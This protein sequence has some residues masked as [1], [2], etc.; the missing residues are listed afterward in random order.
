MKPKILLRIAALLIL[1]FA[2]GHTVSHFARKMTNDPIEK[3]VIRQMEQHKFNVNGSMRSR[4]ELS[5]GLSFD[6]SLVLLVFTSIFS[7]LSG[8]CKKHPKIC[9]NFLWPYLI[10]FI[11]FTITGFLYFSIIS[12][13]TSLV[14]C[15]LIILTMVQLNKQEKLNAV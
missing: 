15:L 8:M 13:I 10:C 7:T 1:F 12:G 6:V 3:E 11:G 4:D 9:L 2:I 5:E 14:I